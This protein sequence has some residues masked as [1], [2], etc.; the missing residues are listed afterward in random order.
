MLAGMAAHHGG[1]DASGGIG[2]D[3]DGDCERST[4]EKSAKETAKRLGRCWT[5]SEFHALFR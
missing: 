4:S 5:L 2:V 1:G 3:W